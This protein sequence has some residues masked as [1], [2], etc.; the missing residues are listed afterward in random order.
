M[1]RRPLEGLAGLAAREEA[2]VLTLNGVLVYRPCQLLARIISRIGN[3]EAWGVLILAMALQPEPRALHC[4]LHMAAVALTGLS[5]YLL[6]KRRTARPR[7]CVR[8]A[9]LQ[10]CPHP[11]DEFSFPSGHT[12]HAVGFAVVALAYF[13]FLGAT[14]AVFAVLTGLVRVVLGL[15]YPS[16]VL[17]GVALGG[18]VALASLAL[19][20]PP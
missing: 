8:L 5:L 6:I 9:G 13:P 7:P 3:G 15:H 19:V 16:D 17:A 18:G 10:Y 2:W 20:P 14:L 12:L 1:W 11:M 4:A